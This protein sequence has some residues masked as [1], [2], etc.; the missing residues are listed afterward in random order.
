MGFLFLTIRNHWFRQLRSSQRIVKELAILDLV[1][2]FVAIFCTA[3]PLID[4]SLCP[5][6]LALEIFYMN[7]N[8]QLFLNR[9]AC[10]FYALQPKVQTRLNIAL[11]IYYVSV[12]LNNISM[13]FSNT[14][15]MEMPAERVALACRVAY[16]AG[17]DDDEG[18]VLALSML[19]GLFLFLAGAF[20]FAMGLI[21]FI[22]YSKQKTQVQK[23]FFIIKL[24]F[25]KTILDLSSMVFVFLEMFS[26]VRDD[27]PRFAILVI[28]KTLSLGLCFTIVQ[29]LFSTNKWIREIVSRIIARI[30]ASPAALE[31]QSKKS[32]SSLKI[33]TKSPAIY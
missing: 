3:I 28:A 17:A 24:L 4:T 15:Y 16:K 13:I 10:V 5:Y 7:S 33:V 6:F 21:G 19:S 11:I 27:I 2:C 18:L 1:S 22:K 25:I 29:N 9:I 12:V 14:S 8:Q 23:T 32:D 30:F 31:H 26:S 20:L